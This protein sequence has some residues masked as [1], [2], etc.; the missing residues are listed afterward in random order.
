[1]T[2]AL[3]A[4]TGVSLIEIPNLQPEI[5]VAISK[6]I[7]AYASAKFAVSKITHGYRRFVRMD[8]HT[9]VEKD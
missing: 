6:K 1:M 2:V 4:E 8:D 5:R 7:P 9:Y 3:I